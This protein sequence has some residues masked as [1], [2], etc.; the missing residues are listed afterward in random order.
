MRPGRASKTIRDDELFCQMG[1]GGQGDKTTLKITEHVQNAIVECWGEGE[2]V[3]H[4]ERNQFDGIIE[5]LNRTH[6]GHCA[7]E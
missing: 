3:Q 5:A 2:N 1:S 4:A 7:Y 6:M